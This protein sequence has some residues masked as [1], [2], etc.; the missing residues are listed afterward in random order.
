[1]KRF[2][3]VF[4]A[5]LLAACQDIADPTSVLV[6]PQAPQPLANLSGQGA[7]ERVVPGRVLAKFQAGVAAEDVAGPLGL[8]VEGRGYQNA[9]V[10]L[11]GAAGN[12]RALAA[13]LARDS[14]VVYAEPDYLREPMKRLRMYQ[15]ISAMDANSWRAAPT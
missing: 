10:M 15:N 2:S 1:M 4:L 9:F 5:V 12:E 8:S 14:R 7:A 13:A 6:E 3:A 11:R